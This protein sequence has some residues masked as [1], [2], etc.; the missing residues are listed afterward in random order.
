MVVVKKTVLAFLDEIWLV[1]HA[2]VVLKGVFMARLSRKLGKFD[3]HQFVTFSLTKLK[4][5]TV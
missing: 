1:V 4:S 3:L 2:T 5:G